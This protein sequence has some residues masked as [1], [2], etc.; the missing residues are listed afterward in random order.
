VKRTCRARSFINGTGTA[1]PVKIQTYSGLE[2][3]IALSGIGGLSAADWTPQYR[4]WSRPEKMDDGGKNL[5][6]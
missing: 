2:I 6:D 5:I 4:Y 1:L 3:C